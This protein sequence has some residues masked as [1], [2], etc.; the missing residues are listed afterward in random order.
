MGKGFIW[1]FAGAVI[2]A[3]GTALL[4]SWTPSHPHRHADAAERPPDVSNGEYLAW[5]AG[6]VACHTAKTANAPFLAGGRALKT[7]YGTFFTPNI[8][9]DRE[10][11]IGGWSRDDFIRAMTQGLSP[12]G[13]HYYPAFPYTSYTRMTTQDL[14]DLKAFLDRVPAVSAPAQ[15]HDLPLPFRFRA[16]LGPW[17]TLYFDDRPFVPDPT[18][19]GAWNRGAYIVSG[20]G[21]CGECHTPRGALGGLD[22]SRPLQ[23]NPHGGRNEKVPG[24][25]AG[26]GGDLEKWTRIDLALALS[27]G[28]APDG[29]SLGGSMGDVVNFATRFLSPGDRDAVIAYLLGN[30]VGK[31]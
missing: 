5:I 29:D 1:L 8:T 18:R 15:P 27:N 31:P 13:E 25:T 21:H 19:S 7:P 10:T 26:P 4:L 14:V 11:G 16:A 17:K 3:L 12:S 9:P 22:T 23:G 6:C 30:S 24:L 20:P 28:L 2:T